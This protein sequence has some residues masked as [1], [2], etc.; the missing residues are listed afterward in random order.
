MTGKQKLEAQEKKIQIYNMRG[1]ICEGCKK[2]IPFS[3]AQLAHRIP[4]TKMYL[5]K[6]GT[7]IIHHNKNLA[8]VCSL[9]CNSSV[10]IGGNPMAIKKLVE[11][12]QEVVKNEETL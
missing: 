1:A 3:E 7:N 2:N 6:Y 9:D 8:L 11:D 10:N 4:Q 5:K 12:I